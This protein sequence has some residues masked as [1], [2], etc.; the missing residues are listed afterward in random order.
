M[1]APY[2]ASLTIIKIVG[3]TEDWAFFDYPVANHSYFYFSCLGQH[4][5]VFF[6]T[7]SDHL[8]ARW[9]RESLTHDP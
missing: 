2:V 1:S 9:L 7:L 6:V 8:R 3:F 5:F 4:L